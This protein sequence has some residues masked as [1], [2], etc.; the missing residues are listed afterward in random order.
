MSYKLYVFIYHKIYFMSFYIRNSLIFMSLQIYILCHNL[1]IILIFYVI[2]YEKFDKF[3]VIQIICQNLCFILC[4][5][6]LE[7]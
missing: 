5:F 2:L 7:I 3:Y 1:S 4:H 6:I